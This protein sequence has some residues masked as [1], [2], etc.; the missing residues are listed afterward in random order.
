MPLPLRC[1]EQVPYPVI[2]GLRRRW[3]EVKTVQETGLRAVRDERILEIARQQG[4]IVYTHDADF[5]RHH[6]AGVEHAG[7]FYHHLLAYSIGEAI[8]QVGLFAHPPEKVD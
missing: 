1:D 7:I 8:H 2:E 6:T 5:L 4:L 3:L